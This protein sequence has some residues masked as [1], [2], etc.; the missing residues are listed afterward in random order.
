MPASESRYGVIMN[1]RQNEVGGF[2]L[3]ELIYIFS[4]IIFFS[5]QFTIILFTTI[6]KDYNQNISDSF[7]WIGGIVLSLLSGYLIILIYD[8]G[9]KLWMK[10]NKFKK[11]LTILITPFGF[12]PFI[13]CAY[14]FRASVLM[15]IFN[16]IL[17]L[18]EVALWQALY[19]GKK[20][21]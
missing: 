20:K 11:L 13:F 2:T 8:F 14:Y 10:K 4:Y 21:K 12:V 9:T 17:A 1:K 19:F 18:G 7:N 6:L 3:I 16:I 15:I 5:Y